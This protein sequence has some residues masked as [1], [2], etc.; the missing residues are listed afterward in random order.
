MTQS[1]GVNWDNIPTPEDNSRPFSTYMFNTPTNTTQQPSSA[2]NT[3]WVTNPNSVNIPTPGDTPDLG[4][5]SSYITDTSNLNTPDNNGIIMQEYL[6]QQAGK[7]GLQVDTP[8]AFS[9]WVNGFTGSGVID[10]NH[11]TFGNALT[12]GHDKFGNKYGGLASPLF[13]FTKAGLQ[14]WVGM[15]QLKQAE[16]NLNFR[17]KAFSSQFENQKKLVNDQLAWQHKARE[18]R[19]GGSGGQ[20]VQL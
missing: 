14:A 17:K 7:G 10:P 11:R 18:D 9:K 12:G 8:N 3:N 1:N 19:S 13:D 4:A 20:L 15:K 2:I 6:K 16:D 5:F